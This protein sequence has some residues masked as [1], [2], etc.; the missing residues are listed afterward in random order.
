MKLK[1]FGRGGGARPKF[2]YVDPPLER[3]KKVLRFR[4][5]KKFNFKSLNFATLELVIFGIKY[6]EHNKSKR[7]T[8]KNLRWQYKKET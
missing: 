3:T 6:F 2:Y 4:G 8:E 5:T 1:E 7:Q